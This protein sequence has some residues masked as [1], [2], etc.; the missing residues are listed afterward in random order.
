VDIGPASRSRFPSRQIGSSSG[1]SDS[2]RSPALKSKP[3]SRNS[4]LAFRRPSEL[5]SVCEPET[6]SGKHSFNEPEMPSVNSVSRRR[7]AS[8]SKRQ[9]HDRKGQHDRAP[10][11]VSKARSD[12]ALPSASIDGHSSRVHFTEYFRV[13]QASFL[14]TGRGAPSPREKG[15]KQKIGRGWRR[16]RFARSDAFFRSNE[17]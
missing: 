8:S 17:K 5:R 14:A 13:L 9:P 6:P 1:E 16:S 7:A 2:G 3:L 15:A 12:G 10:S 4:N 11:C